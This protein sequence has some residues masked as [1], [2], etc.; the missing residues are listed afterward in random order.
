MT[1][2]PDEFRYL[3][4]SRI[5]DTKVAFAAIEEIEVQL[6]YGISSLKFIGWLIVFLLCLIIW[7]IW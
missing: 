1:E 3:E 4:E 5:K 6:R 2:D 7:R